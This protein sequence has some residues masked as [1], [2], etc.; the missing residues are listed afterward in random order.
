[1]AWVNDLICMS[2]DAGWFYWGTE[3]FFAVVKL[4]ARPRV[5][6]GPGT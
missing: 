5:K 6:E 2:T 3:W 1:M 4:S